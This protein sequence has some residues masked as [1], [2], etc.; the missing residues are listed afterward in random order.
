MKKILYIYIILLGIILAQS[1]GSVGTAAS[2][3]AA[4]GDAA[5][6]T[7]RG[8]Y[9]IGF[10]PA[11]LTLGQYHSMEI[12]TVLPLPNFS[13]MAGSEVMTF[14]DF[15]YFFGAKKIG[16]KKVG[17]ALTDADKARLQSLFTQGEALQSEM[18]LNLFS[19][20]IQVPEIGSAF[21]I[22]IRDRFSANGLIDSDLVGFA[23]NGNEVGKKETFSNFSFESV[24]LREYSFSFSKNLTSLLKKE[25]KS[26]HAGVTFKYISGFAYGKLERANMSIETT[27]DTK[28]HVIGDVLTRSAVSPDF[29]VEYD[30][31]DI[32]KK[33]DYTPFPTPAGS[34][35]GID[36]GITAEINR[37]ITAAISITDIGSVNWDKETVEYRM[38]G[39]KLISDFTKKENVDSLEEIFDMKG[40]YIGEFSSDLA[41]AL[42]IGVKVRV[43]KLEGIGLDQKLMVAFDY[44]QGLNDGPFNSE[45]PRF[46]FGCEWQPAHWFM[47][48]NGLTFGGRFGFRWSMGFGFD[49]GLLE[50]NLTTTDFNSL[51]LNNG[52]GRAGVNFGTRWKF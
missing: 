12:A 16:S 49:S 8:V 26:L 24:Y 42:H 28:L 48:R 36:L 5:T 41:T 6:A 46:S 13:V 34:G 30:F 22:G 50:F 25:V 43:D 44:H 21:A 35:F 52:A 20:S 14:E 33:E 18:S 45:D 11:N 40:K 51:L 2:R 17:R 1:G 37:A 3:E 19:F 4:L 31:E 27:S 47:F 38:D 23:L 15:D 39:E 29:G 10:N 7:A 9:T 32:T